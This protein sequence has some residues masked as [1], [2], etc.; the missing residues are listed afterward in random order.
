MKRWLAVLML[1]LMV[2]ET[3]ACGGRAPQK[4][5]IE[6]TIRISVFTPDRF[7]EEAAQKFQALHPGVKVEITEFST[8]EVKQID[9]N[10]VVSGVQDLENTKE[11]YVNNINTELM[12]GKG[13]DILSLRTLPYKKYI[14]R[15]MFADLG[16]MMEEDKSYDPGKYYS[17]FFNAVKSKNGLYVL[18]VGYTY[19]LLAG[20]TQIQA[21]DSEWNWQEFFAAAQGAINQKKGR[22]ILAESDEN[23]F[24]EIVALNCNRFVNEEAKTCSF[25]SPEFINLLKMCKEL[26]NKNC[27]PNN[28]ARM[29]QEMFN[30]VLFHDLI[31]NS[32]SFLASTETS[33]NPA[34]YLYRVPSENRGSN[35]FSP[36]MFAINNASPNKTTAWEFL[37]YLLSDEMQS[38]P[39]LPGFPVNRAALK[40]KVERETNEFLQNTSISQSKEKRIELMQKYADFQE[41]MTRELNTCPYR[42][43]RITRIVKEEAHPFFSGK[44][45]AETVAQTIQNKVNIYLKE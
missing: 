32:V 9:A 44:A 10:T 35:A 31:I 18:P 17:G 33:M 25:D 14:S 26:S 5:E 27:L 24:N 42:D 8:P 34:K 41:V 30:Q 21:D 19:D 43:P 2:F 3:A 15:N 39:A 38:S 29:T 1:V 20:Q 13:A 7:L 28:Q 40:Q 6:G 12:S 11:N 4:K 45:P 16:K 36:E 22:Y 23:V 37:K